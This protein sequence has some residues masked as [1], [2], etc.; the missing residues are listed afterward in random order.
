M[1]DLDAHAPGQ[2]SSTLAKK[3]DIFLIFSRFLP[4]DNNKPTRTHNLTAALARLLKKMKLHPNSM[5]VGI[6]FIISAA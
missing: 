6:V 1:S 4:R 5:R 3:M 2:S